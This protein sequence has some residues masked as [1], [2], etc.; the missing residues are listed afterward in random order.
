MKIELGKVFENKTKMFLIPGLKFYGSTFIAKF[1]GDL[2]KLGY[3][4]H[5]TLLDG[6]EVLKDTRPIFIT[7][8]KGVCTAKTLKA[9]EWFREHPS[10]IA[11]YSCGDTRKHMLVLD[12]PEDL[13][14]AYEKFKEG[15]YSE[16][17]DHKH[18]WEFFDSKSIAYKILTKDVTYMPI[19][20]K[21]LEE[22]FEMEIEDKGSY[23]TSELEFP[24][25]MCKETLEMEI[26]NF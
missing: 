13:H 12:F 11:D 20:I 1:T 7:I 4:V 10:Y 26:F 5:D 3:G 16:M 15:K 6:A 2:F 17:Y 8:D 14:I 19:F 24:Y 18:L 22:F 25:T 9:L 21:K 23:T